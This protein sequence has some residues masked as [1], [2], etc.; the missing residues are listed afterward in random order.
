MR[1]ALLFVVL[2]ACGPATLATSPTS[3]RPPEEPPGESV[4][5]VCAVA[6]DGSLRCAQFG[7]DYSP[8]R[9]DL[10]GTTDSELRPVLSIDDAR[11]VSLG[12][13]H[14]CVLHVGGNVSCFGDPAENHLGDGG[15]F[16]REPIPIEL[17]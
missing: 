13:V 5:D 4:G 16:V 15:T 2:C 10:L 1:H 14:G 9:Y 12:L 6:G 11:A 7:S 3:F 17:P 8:L